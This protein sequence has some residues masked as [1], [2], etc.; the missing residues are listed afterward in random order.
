MAAGAALLGHRGSL[1]AGMDR[2]AGAGA[3]AAHGGS[4]PPRPLPLQAHFTA[5]SNVRRKL[6]S[7][8]LSTELRNKYGVSSG[9]RAG[10]A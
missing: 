1:L 2:W 4:L 6:M 9:R 7:A 3:T 5:P 8:P 10:A